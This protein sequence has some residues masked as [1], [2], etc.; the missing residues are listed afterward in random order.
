VRKTDEKNYQGRG[1]RRSGSRGGRYWGR[2]R[3]RRS[4]ENVQRGSIRR[5]YSGGRRP[6]SSGVQTGGSDEGVGGKP[7]TYGDVRY[8]M[9]VLIAYLEDAVLDTSVF[10]DVLR[11]LERIGK[12]IRSDK[13]E[14]GISW[15]QFILSKGYKTI[16]R[17]AKGAE[18]AENLLRELEELSFVKELGKEVEINVVTEKDEE[19]AVKA[20]I[21]TAVIR[22]GALVVAARVQSASDARQWYRVELVY[23]L[24]MFVRPVGGRC[25]CPDFKYRSREK[26]MCKHMRWLHEG[27][28]K[29]IREGVLKDLI[30][31]DSYVFSYWK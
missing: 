30:D 1:N 6:R 31:F 2:S 21:G 4:G 29:G 27:I 28:V 10:P 17:T 5:G 3:G 7:V 11:I 24:N 19:R 26:G 22:N 16:S 25:S 23:P 9:G 20:I 13:I 14:R 15:M 18:V 8:V 12:R